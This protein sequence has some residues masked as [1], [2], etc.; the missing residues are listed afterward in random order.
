MDDFLKQTWEHLV[1]RIA[2]PLYFR[3]IL[4]PAVASFIGLQAAIRDAR[5]DRRSVFWVY[6]NDR[7]HF[8]EMLREAWTQIA[9]VFIAA[10]VIDI[11]YELWALHW[12]YPGQSV[13]VASVLAVVPY[14][15]IRGLANAIRR[16]WRRT[17][18]KRQSI[19]GEDLKS[20]RK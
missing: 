14:L 1:G 7:A 15:L 4:Q 2:G 16:T 3:L 19:R 5:I 8:P 18:K 20:A 10:L 13:I 17:H 6:R 11:L 12:I 9:K